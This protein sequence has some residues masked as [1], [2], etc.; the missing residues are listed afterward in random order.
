MCAKCRKEDGGLFI[1]KPRRTKR[2]VGANP[3]SELEFSSAETASGLVR[4]ADADETNSAVIQPSAT[5]ES[6]EAFQSSHVS[7]DVVSVDVTRVDVTP[8]EPHPSFILEIEG[9]DQSLGPD[10][11]QMTSWL[12]LIGALCVAVLFKNASRK[13]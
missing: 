13:S 1:P 12:F 10:A 9:S 4:T 11:Y 8:V 7:S 2:S 5:V 6:K 3:E